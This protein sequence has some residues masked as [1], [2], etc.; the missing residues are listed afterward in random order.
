MQGPQSA[1]GAGAAVVRCRDCLPYPFLCGDCDEQRHGSFFALSNRDSLVSGLILPLPPSTGF[2]QAAG[3][4]SVKQ[5][6][7]ITCKCN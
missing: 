7:K 2:M 3:Q 1:N 6:G 5:L 4:I